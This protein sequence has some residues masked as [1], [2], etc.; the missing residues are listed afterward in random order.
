MKY[1]ASTLAN[2][3]QTSVI[4]WT[5][6]HWKYGSCKS[7]SRNKICLIF[8]VVM[9]SF[10]VV[11]ELHIREQINLNQLSF[12]LKTNI[13]LNSQSQ[14]T[15]HKLFR[16]NNTNGRQ[17]DQCHGNGIIQIAMMI[18]CRDE[19]SLSMYNFQLAFRKAK[20]WLLSLFSS[21]CMQ[22]RRNT[23]TLHF[24]TVLAFLC[25]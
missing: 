22:Y 4:P 20:S 25:S 24:I 13:S 14:S 11:C 10:V 6:A 18:M 21:L 1:G 19:L 3:Q 8:F 7:S 9:L 2:L 16:C 5:K 15:N 12:V 17:R 23:H